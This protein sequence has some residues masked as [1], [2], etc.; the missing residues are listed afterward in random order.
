MLLSP[1]A[2]TTALG[3]EH[4]EQLLRLPLRA[5]GRSDRDHFV[6]GRGRQDREL[7]PPVHIGGDRLPQT[8]HQRLPGDDV[9]QCSFASSL[10]FAQSVRAPL[11]EHLIRTAVVDVRYAVLRPSQPAS[12]GG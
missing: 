7:A 2:T 5:L 3:A 8:R 12:F 6:H 1:A 10:R 9:Q 4:L 11:D